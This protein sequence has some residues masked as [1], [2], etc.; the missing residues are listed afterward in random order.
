MDI[1]RIILQGTEGFDIVRGAISTN[2]YEEIDNSDYLNNVW[3]KNLNKFFRKNWNIEEKNQ[4]FG[5]KKGDLIVE[6]N[7]EEILNTPINILENYD[8]LIDKKDCI[9]P[10]T[11]DIVMTSLQTLE[12]TF[13]DV[14]F[15]TE[16][17]FNFNKFKFI[18]K[19]IWDE[20][21]KVILDKLISKVYYDDV[22]LNFEGVETE[23]KMS[24]VFFNN[25]EKL[26]KNEKNIDR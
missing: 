5:L 23:L 17:K 14:I 7:G 20:T 3:N 16:D 11:N 25:T 12:G 13:M 2:D 19:T 1:V 26:Q 10:V 18:E 15:V 24:K 22:L 8:V 4:I 6:L 21:N 9:Y